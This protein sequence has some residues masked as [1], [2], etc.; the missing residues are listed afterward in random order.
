MSGL[1]DRA[2]ATRAALV[3]AKVSLPVI[4]R[5]SGM[6][7][8]RHASIFTGHGHDF[9]DLV[10]YEHG[11]DVA[12]IDWKTSARAGFPIIRRFERES[13]MYTQLVIDTGKDMLGAA[14]SGEVKAEIGMFAANIL[15]YLAISRGDR[16]SVVYG[17]STGLARV[18]ARH[19]NSHL[20]LSLDAAQA[21]LE[22]T[23]GTSAVSAMLEEVLR[24]PQPRSLLLIVTDEY[25]PD[26]PDGRTLRRIRTRHEVLVLRVA[27]MPVS[28][29]GVEEMVDV[30]DG[31][32]IP[33]F[34]RDDA[35]LRRDLYED[36]MRAHAFARDLLRSTG[37][38]HMTVSSSD[39]VPGALIELLGRRRAR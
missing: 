36:R 35:A 17:D 8:G 31:T 14:P 7:E 3:R 28:Q 37:V 20:D 30:L 27:D 12:D 18:P 22:T 16:L 5:A 19:G 23:T 38:N 2:Q 1:S 24:I 11:D 29:E 21:R 6:F 26:L 32:E 25:W 9:E 33:Q 10:E 34:L 4:R 13:D 39:D 15:G